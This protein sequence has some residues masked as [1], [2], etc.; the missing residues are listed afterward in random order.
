M[1]RTLAVSTLIL[2]L[3]APAQSA[4]KESWDFYKSADMAQFGYGVPESDLITIT[5]RCTFKKKPIE[6]VTTVLPAKPRKGQTLK[7]TLTN[8]AVTA[9][10]DGK[11]GH[12]SDHGYHFVADIPAE[13]KLL[14]VLKSGTT[15]TISVPGGKPV[16]VP[17][18]GVAKPL[19]Q[20]E[21]ACLNK[22]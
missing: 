13:P 17:L 6:L 14:D 19:A 22:R 21:S 1:R 20:F 10:Y 15:L 9:T 7:T 4:D 18:K 16:R 12:H 11:T 2:A 3:A 8:G 5:F